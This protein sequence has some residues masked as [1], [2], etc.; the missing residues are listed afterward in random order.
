MKKGYAIKNTFA[1]EEERQKEGQGFCGKR[2]KEAQSGK[3][4]RKIGAKTCL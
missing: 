1:P 4:L 2:R 3:K